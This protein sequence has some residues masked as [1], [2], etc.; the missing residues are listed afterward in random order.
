MNEKA[1]RFG[2][3]QLLML[4]AALAAVALIVW[5]VISWSNQNRKTAQALADSAEDLV[6]TDML[7][8]TQEGL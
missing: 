7:P 5:G 4:L 3:K 1:S 6:T 8:D 2:G